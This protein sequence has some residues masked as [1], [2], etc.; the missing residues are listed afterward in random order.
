MN[1][2]MAY[3]WALPA[4]G[5]LTYVISVVWLVATAPRPSGRRASFPPE[6][7]L[8][9]GRAPEADVA[10]STPPPGPADSES[11]KV[12]P[13]HCSLA[14]L[15]PD[16]FAM[17]TEGL[18]DTIWFERAAQRGEDA[19]PFAATNAANTIG[20][21]AVADGLG[22]AGN[23]RI[24]EY[25]GTTGAKLASA[26]VID[27]FGEYVLSLVSNALSSAPSRLKS[28]D[29]IGLLRS[30]ARKWSSEDC[31]VK[32]PS[33]FDGQLPDSTLVPA[34]VVKD[35]IWTSHITGLI[36]AFDIDELAA[37]ID[38]RMTSFSSRIT[39]EASL[40][41]SKMIHKLPTTFC[42]VVF[43][44]IGGRQAVP[45]YEL[46]TI[47]AG[48]SRAY[49]VTPDGLVQLTVE[50]GGDGGAQHV[51]AGRMENCVSERT[52][53]KLQWARRTLTGPS[54]VFACSDGVY[55]LRRS[56][57]EFSAYL[58][59]KVSSSASEKDLAS[60][61]RRDFESSAGDDCSI[62]FT[63]LAVAS[64]DEFR[65]RLSADAGHRAKPPG[66]NGQYRP[67]LQP[68]GSGYM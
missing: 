7:Y 9:Y 21:L 58:V 41:K 60:R 57:A 64:F 37:I 26:L 30:F 65:T 35:A 34:V 22:G 10:P 43:E 4:A 13:R 49:A 59:D 16:D 17:S 3:E 25:N 31:F 29:T 15:L 14:L 32:K 18:T 56:A 20:F 23:Q 40:V 53:N 50:N 44:K 61:I 19:M 6:R 39:A 12:L 66:S 62:A 27:S 36:N 52:P 24:R 54:F 33:W 68:E 42:A 55:E 45:T 8:P 46:L 63:F 48:D 67:G 28:T 38:R 51:A 11:V 2:E 1:P 5:L 47:W